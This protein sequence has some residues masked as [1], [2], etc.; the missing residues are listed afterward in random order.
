MN[1]AILRALEKLEGSFRDLDLKTLVIRKKGSKWCLYTSDGSRELGCHD[2][3]EGAEAQEAAV[4]ISKHSEAWIEKQGGLENAKKKYLEAS[5][6][7]FFTH[8][9]EDGIGPG[10]PEFCAWLHNKLF[11]YYPNRSRGTRAAR[12]IYLK[13]ATGEIR[14]AT[15]QDREHVVVP[16]IALMEGV[17]H[18][19]NA[20]TPELVLAEELEMAPEGWNGRPVVYDHP[21]D[22]PNRVSANDPRVLEDYSFGTVFNAHM[23]GKK[24]KMEAWLDPIRAERVGEKAVRVLER[25]KDDEMV[26]VSVGVF[27]SEE[28]RTGI[29]NGK[30]Y[31]KVWRNIVPDHLAMLPDGVEGACSIDMGCGAPRAAEGKEKRMGE[32]N[33]NSPCQAKM[34]VWER[35]KNVITFRNNQEDAQFSDIDLREALDSA[36]RMTEPGYQGVDAVFPGENLVVYSV[37]PGDSWK[38][39]RRGF[40]INDKGEVQLKGESGEEVRPVTR[41]E[42]VE[43][44]GN[45]KG[46]TNMT[47]KMKELI[48]ALIE[49]DSPFEEV[50]TKYLETLSEEK[51]TMLVGSYKKPE[52]EPKPEPKPEPQAKAEP[53]P[54]KEE[55]PKVKTEEEYLAELPE[56]MKEVFVEHKAAQAKKKTDL[57][58]VLKAAQDV[59]SEDELRKKSV[60]ELEQLVR[61]AKVDAPKPDYSGLGVPRSGEDGK[62]PEP[63]PLAERLRSARQ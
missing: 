41:F 57:V 28:S 39:M 40:S 11:G 38:T 60:A 44:A 36:L 14:T 1:E 30:Q 8:C 26:E 58:T 15:F 20:P 35:L 13:R 17:I 2:S 29:H 32:E 45:Q 10:T 34:T 22:G 23:D 12:L 6:P 3:K 56:E 31:E 18:A 53:E 46:K 19:V 49:N 51:L 27:I 52:P 47:E 24:L 21:I 33:K 9:V 59:F 5:E 25:I 37:M 55:P 48:K 7:G 16:V 54:K 4:Q 50:D 63:P 42:L 43:A 62:V 61:V